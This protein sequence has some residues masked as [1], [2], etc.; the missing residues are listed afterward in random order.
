L[1]LIG[2]YSIPSILGM[3][4]LIPILA[5]HMGIWGEPVAIIASWERLQSIVSYFDERR[6]LGFVPCKE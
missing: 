3:R 5:V 1:I 2:G 4:W 6:R